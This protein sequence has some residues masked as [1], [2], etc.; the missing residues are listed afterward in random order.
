M[1]I[2][3]NSKF[4]TDEYRSSYGGEIPRPRPALH[5]IPE[6]YKKLDRY[7]QGPELTRSSSKT[8]KTCMPF[9]DAYK[10][11][12]IIPFATDIY[13]FYDKEQKKMNFEMHDLISQ[14]VDLSQFGVAA[15]NDIQVPTELRYNRRSIDKVWKFMNSWQITTPKGYSC[16]FTQPKNQNLPFQIID[17]VVDTDDYPFIVNFPFYWTLDSNEKFMIKQGSPMVQVIP[18][19][20]EEWTAS[21]GQHDDIKEAKKNTFNFHSHY[22]SAYKKFFMKKKSFK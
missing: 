19:K 14:T 5:Y 3:F 17:G 8:V 11:G 7:V 16:I 21:Y 15:H 22:E 1:K 4:N 6:P 18:F 20:R 13:C 9:L 10:T 12:Y 2:Q